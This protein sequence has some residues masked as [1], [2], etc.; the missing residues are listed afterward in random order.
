MPIVQP[1]RS[2]SRN[3]GHHLTPFT[4]QASTSAAADQTPV[5][6]SRQASQHCYSKTVPS[7]PNAG[8]S[9]SSRV[10]APATESSS[11]VPAKRPTPDSARS[12]RQ[13]VDD[14]FS[15]I[16]DEDPTGDENLNPFPPKR[17]R[18]SLDSGYGRTDVSIE[19]EVDTKNEALPLRP[20][21][22]LLGQDCAPPQLATNSRF[23]PS[24]PPVSSG[25][26]AAGLSSSASVAANRLS[27][28]PAASTSSADEKVGV[29]D[30]SLS[31]RWQAAD[32]KCS[33]D[34]TRVMREI[35]EDIHGKE[36]AHARTASR[37]AYDRRR[38]HCRV[39]RRGYAQQL[40]VSAISRVS[41]ASADA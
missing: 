37:I 22:P 29:V 12:S 14:S 2:L 36:D 38:I 25:S 8:A 20:D 11:L 35:S 41:A 34:A 15:C 6:S 5:I 30:G 27:G 7:L 26:H 21:S 39:A 17:A 4:P 16:D 18:P 10:A 32:K 9:S 31:T 40:A 28:T 1:L 24:N 19:V 3:G 33:S 13:H 23:W